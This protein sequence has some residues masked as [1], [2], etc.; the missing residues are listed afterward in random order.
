MVQNLLLWLQLSDVFHESFLHGQLRYHVC[1]FW[2]MGLFRG[3]GKHIHLQWRLTLIANGLNI[4][5]DPYSIFG[6]GTWLAGDWKVLLVATTIWSFCLGVIEL[7]HLFNLQA[8]TLKILKRILKSA[9]EIHLEIIEYFHWGNGA[10]FWSIRVRL[11]CLNRNE[12]ASLDSTAFGL[13]YTIA[14]SNFDFHH[15]ACLGIYSVLRQL[16]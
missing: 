12:F 1:C 2:S 5:L 11:D 9:G 10:V 15:F 14:I 3:R 16:W 7:Y 4:F 6:F 8:T 13:G